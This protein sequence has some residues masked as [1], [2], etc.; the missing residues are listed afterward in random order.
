[1]WVYTC[2]CMYVCLC[3]S[4]IPFLLCP[5]EKESHLEITLPNS[6]RLVLNLTQI[7]K[8][9]DTNRCPKFKKIIMEFK[10]HTLPNDFL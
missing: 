9:N 4:P 5:Y 7:H 6:T 8:N 2:M 3:I 10:S 1:M